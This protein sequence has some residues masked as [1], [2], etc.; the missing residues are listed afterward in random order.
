MSAEDDLRHLIQDWR[1]SH[2]ANLDWRQRYYAL[3]DEITDLH[4][5]NAALVAKLSRPESEEIERLK[6]QVAALSGK[7]AVLMEALDAAK[8]R[9]KS[10][11]S[12][13]YPLFLSHL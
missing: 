4:A 5:T 8:L 1:D 6:C 7:C 11:A 9:R 3:R 12:L 10:S 2:L 13:F